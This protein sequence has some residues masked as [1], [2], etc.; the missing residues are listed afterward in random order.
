[1]RD[2]ERKAAGTD[3]SNQLQCRSGFC[4]Y[5]GVT[6]F[7]FSLYWSDLFFFY[8]VGVTT[9]TLAILAAQPTDVVK[10]RMQAAGNNGQY[11]VMVNL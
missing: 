5:E 1:M 4:R 10:V 3:K 11:K 2:K 6:K 7:F 9:G 8:Y